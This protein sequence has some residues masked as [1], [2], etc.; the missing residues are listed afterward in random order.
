MQFQDAC[1]ALAVDVA[2]ACAGPAVSTLEVAAPSE[3]SKAPIFSAE[4]LVEHSVTFTGET[5]INLSPHF[6]CLLGGDFSFMCT[7][8]MD[9]ARPWSRLF[10]FSLEADEDSITAGAIEL[11][12]DFHFTIFRGKKPISVRVDGFFKLGEEFTVLCTVSAAGH[13]RVFKDGVLVGERTGGMAP[14][15]VDRPRMMVGGHYLFQDQNFCGSMKD[16]K[17]WN[18][19]VPWEERSASRVVVHVL[20]EVC[21]EQV[22]ASACSESDGGFRGARDAVDPTSE[23]AETSDSEAETLVSRGDEGSARQFGAGIGCFEIDTNTNIGGM[24]PPREDDPDLG[25]GGN[26]RVSHPS[27]AAAALPPRPPE[28]TRVRA[29]WSKFAVGMLGRG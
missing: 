13:M 23:D 6:P 14:L 12:Q 27:G 19:E 3:A 22:E 26:I 29:G 4:P 7:A 16:V 5:P 9:G 18:Q 1:V 11:T 8:R 17:V 20:G 25:D 15:H 24:L 28:G 21:S 10:D 2:D